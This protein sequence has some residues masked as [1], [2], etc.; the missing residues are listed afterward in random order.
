MD[1]PSVQV[2]GLRFFNGEV[3]AAAKLLSEQG[4]YLVAPSGTCF[5]RLDHDAVYREAM[6]NADIILPDSGAMVLLARVFLRKSLRRISGLRYT[7]HL[8]HRLRS[9]GKSFWVVPNET[10]R[11][12]L[13]RWL[14]QQQLSFD[15]QVAIYVAPRYAATVE[16]RQLLNQIEKYRPD[17]V[18][19]GIGSGPQEKLGYFLRE[20]LSY[21]PAIHCIGAALGF[22]TGDQVAIPNWA[23][24]SYLGWLFRLISQP[25]VFIPRLTRALAL[26]WLMLRHGSE[27]PP[28]RN[29]SKR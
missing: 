27:L 4:G 20:N 22:L 13:E 19:I 24:K 26:P 3:E 5:V 29:E 10:A 16:D 21:R 28:L 8:A 17:H 7:V 14:V 1:F 18:V 23:D 12:K 25:R 15:E 2:L 6:L 9:S 11:A